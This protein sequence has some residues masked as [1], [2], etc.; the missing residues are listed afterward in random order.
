MQTTIAPYWRNFIGGQWVDAANGGRIAVEDPATGERIAEIARGEAAD[1]DRAVAEARRCVDSG[2]LSAMRPSARGHL[3]QEVGR[4]L[5]AR[6]DEIAPILTLE[7]GK[8]L[9]QARTEIEG[10]AAYFEYYGGLAAGIEG[11]YIPLGDGYVDYVVPT[12]FGVSAQIVPWNF[13]LEMAARSIAPALAAGNAAVVK[14]PELDPLAVALLG[15]ICA[16]VGLPDGAV[17][18]VCGYGH[19]AGAA[20]TAHP[21]VDQIVFTGSVETGRKILHAAAERIVPAVVE[22]GGKSAGIVFPDAD[23][24]AVTESAKWGIYFNS[25]QVCSAMSRLLVH[26]S[27]KDEVVERIAA[28]T[29][30]LS[31]GPGLDENFITPLISAEQL[32]RVE[33][34]ALSGAQQGAR[35]VTGGRRAPGRAGHFMQPTVFTEV[36]PEMR[37]AAEEIFGPVLSIIAYD[38]EEQALA[39]ANGTPF[40]LAA[41]LFTADLDRAHRVAHRLEAGQVFVNEWYA[42]GIE[43]PFGGFKTSGIGREKGQEAL[44]NYY[45][46]KNIGIRRLN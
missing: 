33:G 6:I 35:A 12:P 2:A 31:M 22:L 36:T 7:S 34:Y 13:P 37:I 14:S 17:N 26:R 28:M 4:R 27:V 24:D 1:V 40:G 16:E 23:L 11:R 21:G 43:T 42:G 20:L 46:S 25:G 41:G 15:E 44:G 19:D 39:I 29:E 38:D 32:D 9:T 45:Q 8:N 5:R 18:V 3:V 30:G 10:S